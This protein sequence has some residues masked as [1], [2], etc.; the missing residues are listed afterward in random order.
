MGEE[1]KPWMA[2]FAER[3]DWPIH[4][5][6]DPVGTETKLNA[7]RLRWLGKCT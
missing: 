5:G 4:Q 7:I 1:E 2:D 6:Y 3:S